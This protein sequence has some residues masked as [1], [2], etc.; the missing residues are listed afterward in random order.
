V[1]LLGRHLRRKGH[2]AETHVGVSMWR[3]EGNRLLDPEESLNSSFG[4]QGQECASEGKKRELKAYKL[5]QHRFTWL[6]KSRK[7]CLVWGLI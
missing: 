7:I 2:K 4:F 5:V 6:R 3:L 1:K